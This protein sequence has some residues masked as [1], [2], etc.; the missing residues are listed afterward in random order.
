MNKFLIYAWKLFSII[1][2]G[3][4]TMFFV[5]K[6]FINGI[7][8]VSKNQNIYF[9][10]KFNQTIIDFKLKQEKKEISIIGTSRAAG[11]EKEMFKNQSV[12]NYSM[13]T[14]SLKDVYN[15]IQEL[16]FDTNDTLIFGIDQWNFNKDYLHRLT[17]NFKN[18]NLNIPFLFFDEVK[19]FTNSD[20]YHENIV[21][22]NIKIDKLMQKMDTLQTMM[23]SLIITKSS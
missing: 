1:S 17:N 19:N 10:P 8:N 13:I 5:N 9:N 6:T 20:Y 12:Y 2:I 7:I 22:M 14:W 23:Q 21:N 18:N 3:L 16:E 15:L 4:I 11:F